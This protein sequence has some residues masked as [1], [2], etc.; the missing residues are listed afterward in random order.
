MKVSDK[1]RD[2]KYNKKE[3]RVISVIEKTKLI[4]SMTIGQIMCINWN[5]MRMLSSMYSKPDSLKDELS[6]RIKFQ[7]CYAGCETD[8]KRI[9]VAKVINDSFDE[10]MIK[11][12]KKYAKLN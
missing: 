3:T 7:N 5:R 2:I 6:M 12:V 10:K 4:G 8:Q 9:D 1:K 11:T